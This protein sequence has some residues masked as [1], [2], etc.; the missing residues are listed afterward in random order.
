MTNILS[1]GDRPLAGWLSPLILLIAL[2]TALPIASA[3]RAQSLA[4]VPVRYDVASNTIYIG[5]NYNDPAL[6]AYPSAP[7]SRSLTDVRKAPV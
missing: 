6:I 7:K 5:E 4:A 2:V 1:R 3:A